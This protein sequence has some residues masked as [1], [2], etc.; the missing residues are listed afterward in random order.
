MQDDEIIYAIKTV[1]IAPCGH[2]NCS[3]GFMGCI[4]EFRSRL[5][6]ADFDLRRAVPGSQIKVAV[7][8]ETGFP[9][10]DWR[11][12]DGVWWIEAGPYRPA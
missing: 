10:K 8:H 12:I 9:E 6:V 7:I 3:A 5:G 1:T 2:V 4:Y 11:V